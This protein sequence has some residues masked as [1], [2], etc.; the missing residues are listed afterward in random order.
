[1]W[2]KFNG[3]F[4]HAPNTPLTILCCEEKA[5]LREERHTTFGSSPNVPSKVMPHSFAIETL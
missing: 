1:M 2:M 4:G 5:L 3:V